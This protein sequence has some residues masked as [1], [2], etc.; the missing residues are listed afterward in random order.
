M[1]VQLREDFLPLLTCNEVAAHPSPIQ[2]EFLNC[3]LLPLEDLHINHS[4][5]SSI[6][7]PALVTVCRGAGGD[8]ALLIGRRD[9]DYPERRE[10]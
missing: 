7:C 3:H 4:R 1:Q 6:K 9:V 8:G 10:G 5:V 2:L